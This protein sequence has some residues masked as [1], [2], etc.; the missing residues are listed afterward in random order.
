MIQST[1]TA[2]T[3]L[4]LGTEGGGFFIV[5]Q[6]DGTSSSGIVAFS[7]AE[8]EKDDWLGIV[9]QTVFQGAY[10]RIISLGFPLYDLECL[11]DYEDA[12]ANWE[13]LTQE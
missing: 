1:D 9:S 8:I 11:A 4:F 3:R 2:I 12:V 7:K 13:K 6:S 5:G 10:D